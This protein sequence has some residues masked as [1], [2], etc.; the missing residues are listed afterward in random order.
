MPGAKMVVLENRARFVISDRQNPERLPVGMDLRNGGS[1]A[2]VASPVE[3]RGTNPV[4]LAY[5]CLF[6]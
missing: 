4:A 6:V 1:W 5:T 3:R 2:P